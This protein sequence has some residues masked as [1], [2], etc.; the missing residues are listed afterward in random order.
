MFSIENLLSHSAEYFRRGSFTVAKNS[1]IE[2]V[3]LRVGGGGGE[4]QDFR[5]KFFCLTAPKIFVGNPFAPCFRKIP[6][7]KKFMDKWAGRVK[8]FHQNSSVSQFRKTS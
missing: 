2:K 7:A 3:W 5:S 8:I 4:D 6:V 1:G